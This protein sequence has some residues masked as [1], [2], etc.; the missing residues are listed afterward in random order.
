ML[1]TTSSGSATS[2]CIDSACQNSN[3]ASL[4]IVK[5]GGVKPHLQNEFEFVLVRLVIG[6]WG[7]GAE[8]SRGAK[9]VGSG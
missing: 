7:V 2:G 3:A 1:A 6:W 4:G 8:D 5:A 9:I